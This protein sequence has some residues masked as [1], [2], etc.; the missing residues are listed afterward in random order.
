MDSLLVVYPRAPV[1][2]DGAVSYTTLAVCIYT[3][4]SHELTMPRHHDCLLYR[5]HNIIDITEA[6]IRTAEDRPA[7]VS[8]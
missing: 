2:A 3:F 5:M 1:L 4:V 6:H 7:S 8:M